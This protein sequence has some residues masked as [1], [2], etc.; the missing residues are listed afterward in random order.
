MRHLF[1]FLLLAW[2]IPPTLH[3]Q[4]IEPKQSIRISLLIPSVS[5][6]LGL[7]QKWSFEAR[8]FAGGISG[9]Y[10]QMGLLAGFNYQIFK[11][12]HARKEL[13]QQYFSGNFISLQTGYLETF[14]HDGYSK[15]LGKVICEHVWRR[16]F[17]TKGFFELGIGTSARYDFRVNIL[18]AAFSM[19]LGLGFAL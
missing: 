2:G 19:R 14:F 15:R 13:R 12:R 7:D 5:Y 9:V 6:E 17:H 3:A 16:S 10:P 4:D 1:L 8:Y 11:G 18:D